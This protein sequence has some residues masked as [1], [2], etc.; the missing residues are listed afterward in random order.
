MIGTIGSLVQVT[1]KRRRWLVVASLY[2]GACLSSAVLLG[3]TVS[4]VG[5]G[6]ASL[7]APV[8]EWSALRLPAQVL[9]G[10]LAVAYGLSDLGVIRLPRPI[11]ATAVPVTWWRQWGPYRAA[12]AYGAALGLGI[13]T[14]IPFGAFYIVCLWCAFGADPVYGAALMGTYGA[15]RGLVIFPVSWGAARDPEGAH[16][17]ICHHPGLLNAQHAQRLLSAVLIAVGLGMVSTLLF[18]LV[19]PL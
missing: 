17:W 1:S 16:G 9:L 4:L 15:A 2:S 18:P 8:A 3:A 13:T 5:R 14:R 7:A 11:I 19:R 6:V 12:L 10:A